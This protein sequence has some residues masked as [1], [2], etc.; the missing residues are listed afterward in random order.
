MNKLIIIG[1]GFDLAHGLKT[2]Y[3]NFL[4][5]LF[6]KSK[7]TKKSI[8]KFNRSL[9]DREYGR[10]D[11]D[12]SFFIGNIRDMFVK[13]IVST[14]NSFL[15]ILYL[16]LSLQDWVDIEKRYYSQL[17]NTVPK[18]IEKLNNEFQQIKDELENY[19]KEEVPIFIDKPGSSIESRKFIDLFENGNSGK[20]CFLNFNYTYTLDFYI[21]MLQDT[22]GIESEVINIHGRLSDKNNPIIFGYGDEE[23][24]SHTNLL[25]KDNE[26]YLMNIKSTLY[27]NSYN[28]LLSFLSHAP[29]IHIFGHSLGI[30]DRTLLKEILT[31]K[32]VRSIKLYYYK[33]RSHYNYL[34][35]RLAITF[36]EDKS[37]KTK[38]EE[39][40][41]STIMP[42]LEV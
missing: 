9:K 11:I 33:N 10:S 27:N 28:R 15:K 6:K 19:L 23:D 22:F 12:F 18:N 42:Q 3:S 2:S 34:K 41:S 38:V 25:K 26:V 36:M 32:R 35:R 37:W 17:I 40:E 20:I 30:S 14:D 8:L 16:D 13:Q 39:I 1:N 4:E 5:Y 7:T 24:E 21:D 31:D 29:T